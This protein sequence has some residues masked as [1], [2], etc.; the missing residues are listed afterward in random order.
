[1]RR[2]SLETSQE[3]IDTNQTARQH[4]AQLSID[5]FD[6]LAKCL[7]VG[8]IDA[9]TECQAPGRPTERSESESAFPG[10]S[11]ATSVVFA[12]LSDYRST[13]SRLRGLV[14]P[15]MAD[16]CAVHLEG[17]D[18]HEM[19]LADV[20]PAKVELLRS[21]CQRN[22]LP[23]DSPHGYP[24]VVRT[25]EPQTYIHRSSRRSPKT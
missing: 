4:G 6:I 3:A 16:W 20:G 9:A 18:A 25:G 12:R 5:E 7:S 10:G 17:N 15:R 14:V 13:L 24:S 11:R 21:I 19:P 8:V 22:P 2:T 1:M 23:Q